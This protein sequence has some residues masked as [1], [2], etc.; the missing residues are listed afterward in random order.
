MA[1]AQLSAS[2]RTSSGKGAARSLRRSGAVPGVIYGHAREPQPLQVNARELERLLSHISAENT[3]V[4][5]SLDG[6]MSRT[7]IREIQRDAIR[8]HVLHVDFQEL[9]A[10]EKVTVRIPIVLVGIPVGVRANGGIMSQVLNELECLV[11]PANIPSRIEFD[12]TEL[13]IG[14]SVHVGEIVVPEGVEVMQDADET[15]VV[16]A[17]PKEEK[18]AEPAEETAT[19]AEPEL[20]RK[21]KGEEEEEE[22]K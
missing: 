4:E 19:L 17:A 15:V 5:L 9:V 2:A 21:P 14:R 8:R 3:V 18:V 1:N 16:V 10:G 20:I 22:T 13:N 6:T 7:L 12:V 11:D